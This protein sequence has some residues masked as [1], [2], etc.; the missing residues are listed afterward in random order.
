MFLWLL[1]RL[2]SIT[3]VFWSLSLDRGEVHVVVVVSEIVNT[4]VIDDNLTNN[5]NNMNHSSV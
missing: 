2:S 1:V 5:H 3:S 4:L